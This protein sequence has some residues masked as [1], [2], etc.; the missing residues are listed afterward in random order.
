MSWLI[1]TT[2]KEVVG[3]VTTRFRTSCALADIAKRVLAIF[4]V[5]LTA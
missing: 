2:T 1:R 4:G 3:L 5:H